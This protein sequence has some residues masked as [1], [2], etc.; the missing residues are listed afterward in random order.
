MESSPVQRAFIV[1]CPRSGTTLLQGMLAAH[2]RICSFPETHFF[3]AAFPL[4]PLRRHLVWPALGGR[5]CLTHWLR[6]LRR[7]DLLPLARLPWHT[8]DYA[9]GFVAV[10]D[11]LAREAGAPWWVEKT[12]DH[13]RRVEHIQAAMPD[14]R[15]IHLVRDGVETV[16]SLHQASQRDPRAWH[17][18][19][20]WLGKG[21]T[22]TDCI[23]RWNTAVEVADRWA[24][25]PRHAIVLYDVLVAEPE[26]V[27]RA[28]A[29]FLD[30]PYDPSMLRPEQSFDR[31]VIKAEPW[32]VNNTGPIQRVRTTP[33]D[34]LSPEQRAR[35]ERALDR[36]AYERVRQKALV[37]RSP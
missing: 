1:G 33:A 32:K 12:P 4:N 3:G 25:D 15:F 9:R 19:W 14:A 7:E 26:R 29:A 6:T 17:A 35:L 27:A 28:L 30:I 22:W 24:G 11:Q 37:T 5:R 23:E 16:C 2:P 21:M 34:A 20:R 13:F 10:L 18:R 36:T 8:R 31:I